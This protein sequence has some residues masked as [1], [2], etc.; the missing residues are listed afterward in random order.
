[1]FGVLDNKIIN[2]FTKPNKYET[3]DFILGRNGLG[4][5]EVSNHTTFGSWPRQLNGFHGQQQLRTMSEPSINVSNTN[6]LTVSSSSE[7][8]QPR[9][10]SLVL[11]R[12]VVPIDATEI[13][14]VPIIF[15]L[16]LL[17]ILCYEHYCFMLQSCFCCILK[18]LIQQSTTSLFFLFRRSRFW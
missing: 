6:K 11:Q 8:E 14:D 17:S 4:N 2:F 18:Y 12:K 10:V 16:G 15:I 13:P 5:H 7:V 9:H 3:W 1:M